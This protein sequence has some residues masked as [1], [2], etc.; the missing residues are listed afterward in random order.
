MMM[1]GKSASRSEMHLACATLILKAPAPHARD[2][3]L[4]LESRMLVGRHGAGR[5]GNISKKLMF[6]GFNLHP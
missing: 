3:E 5:S 1:M 6:K 4:S 2:I